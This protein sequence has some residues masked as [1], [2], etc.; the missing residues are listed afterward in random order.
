MSIIS[1]IKRFIA[2][3]GVCAFAAFSGACSMEKENNEYA[4]LNSYLFIYNASFLILRFRLILS[5]RFHIINKNIVKDIL[6]HNA[7]NTCLHQ[8]Q[9]SK[10]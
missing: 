2:I 6:L 10:K 3:T 4:D 8:L 7:D 5:I 1:K 9:Y